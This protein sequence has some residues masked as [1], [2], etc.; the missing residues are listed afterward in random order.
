[1]SE[2]LHADWL[3]LAGGVRNDMW[4]WSHSKVLPEL[5]AA[6]SVPWIGHYDTVRQPDKATSAEAFFGPGNTPDDKHSGKTAALYGRNQ[7]VNAPH[8]A[9]AQ[10]NTKKG[11]NHVH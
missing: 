6:D 4:A 11:E 5:Q 1:M 9:T 7:I 3:D 10:L 8:P 2:V